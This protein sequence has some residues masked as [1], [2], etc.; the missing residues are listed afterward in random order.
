[1][2]YVSLSGFSALRTENYIERY[3][4]F[5]EIWVGAKTSLA[6]TPLSKTWVIIW[7]RGNRTPAF[8]IKTQ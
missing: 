8:G 1:M 7:N 5:L 2:V 3:G 4:N 6:K